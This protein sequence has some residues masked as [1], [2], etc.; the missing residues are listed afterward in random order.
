MLIREQRTDTTDKH[1]VWNHHTFPARQFLF[2]FWIF[3]FLNLEYFLLEI[4]QYPHP[5]L[6][7]KSKP[8]QRVDAELRKII[9]E[10]FQLM[11]HAQGIGLAANQVNLPLRL[12]VI[13]TQ[14]DP[15]K[16]EE[17]VFINPEIQRPK[18]NSEQEE[19]CL[20]LPG[21]YGDVMRP[22]Q[23]QVTAYN[24]DGQLYDE[25]VD[26]LLARVIQ[27][28]NDHINGVMFPDRMKEGA[29]ESIDHLLHEFELDFTA[30]QNAGEIPPPDEFAAQRAQWE[31]RYC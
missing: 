6:R 26:G 11:Y 9:R 28:E 12:F 17:L 16:G 30:R 22:S 14:A 20:S 23:I 4:V 10:M 3:L 5:A 21:V 19:G 31:K 15:D 25:V 2:R 7:Y 18:G 8:I 29:R 27:H 24:Q 1:F 13:N